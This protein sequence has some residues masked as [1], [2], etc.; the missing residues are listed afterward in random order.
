M[1]TILVA[2]VA[3]GFAPSFYLRTHFETGHS[4]TDLG[5]LPA[6]LYV[7]GIVLTLWYLLF[8][9]QTVLVASHRIHVHRYLGVNGAVLAVAVFIASMLVVARSVDRYASGGVPSARPPIAVIGDIGIL[10]LFALFVAGGIRFRRRSDVHKRL[11]LLASISI[12][13]PAI[14]RLPG[15]ATLGPIT[16]V[17]V[18]L[19]LFAALVAYDIISSRRVHPA[20]VW[21]L[22]L[23]VLVAVTSFAVGF[24]EFGRALVSGKM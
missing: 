8:W 10:V 15:A 7:H 23:Y 2:I 19:S 22:A 13:A 12:V 11:M 21:G 14:S 6:Y 4:G 20:T 3:V 9:A 1:A 5:T 18:Q 24:S 16:V 17:L